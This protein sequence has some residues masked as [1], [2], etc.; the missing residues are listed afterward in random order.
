MPRTCDVDAKVKVLREFVRR[1]RRMP[2]YREMLQL[3]RYRSKNAVFG[4]LRK[5]SDSGHLAKSRAGKLAPTGRLTGHVRLLG[6]V[7]A[8][9][10]SPAEEELLDT[11]SL[12][13]FLIRRRRRRSCSRSPA[14]PCSMPA[15]IPATWFSSSVAL[16]PSPATSSWHRWMT[17]GR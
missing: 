13:E 11:M 3:F 14:T 16:R 12:D 7:Q 4:L 10:P 1:E 9:F 2:G 17:N 5:L 15:S 6:H 8:G